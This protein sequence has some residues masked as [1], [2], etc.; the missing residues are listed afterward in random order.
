MHERPY[1]QQR[2]EQ[3]SQDILTM[4]HDVLNQFKAVR[5]AIELT[6]KTAAHK[7]IQR[8]ESIN[9]QEIAITENAISLII[10]ESPVAKDLRRVIT[11]MQIANDLE[12]IGDYA[13]NLAKYVIHTQAQALYLD[14]IDAFFPFLESMFLDL[15]KAYAAKDVSLAMAVAKDD[16]NIDDLF[17]KHVKEFIR[18]VKTEINTSAEEAGRAILVIKQLERAGDHLTNIAEAIIYLN[19]ATHVVLN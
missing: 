13:A 8:D 15:A 3:L 17:D 9:Q 7:I 18:I 14:A 10:K 5:K 16:Q 4:L 11:A 2:L 19:K 1:F 6:D 12:R